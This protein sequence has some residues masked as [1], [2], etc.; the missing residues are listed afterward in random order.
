MRRAF[1]CGISRSGVGGAVG[2]EMHVEIRVRG[3]DAPP[4]QRMPFQRGLDSIGLRAQFVAGIKREQKMEGRWRRFYRCRSS[5]YCTEVFIVVVK[6]GQING[7]CGA[8]LIAVS[9]FVRQCFL[10]PI[11]TVSG[12]RG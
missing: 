7:E 5:L 2:I 10:I 9:E 8:E 6:S 3:L 4:V 11:P 12:E 1:T